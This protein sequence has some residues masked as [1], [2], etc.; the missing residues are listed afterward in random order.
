MGK[1]MYI[2]IRGEPAFVEYIKG[3]IPLDPADKPKLE[4]WL[5]IG[6]GHRVSGF[7]ITL[8]LREYTLAGLKEKIKQVGG[9]EWDSILVKQER[10]T[11]RLWDYAER[12]LAAQEIAR[13]VAETTGVEL[14]E[15]KKGF[16]G[17]EVTKRLAQLRGKEKP[18]GG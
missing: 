5:T 15:D 2:T 11:V 10:E 17:P 14:L 3:E 16:E 18:K 1:G 4:V 9:Q 6:G 8:P 12:K 7:G 13:K